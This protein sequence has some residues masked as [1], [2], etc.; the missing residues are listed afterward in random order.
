[1]QNA[2]EVWRVKAVSARALCID[3][4]IRAAVG[5]SIKGD[6]PAIEVPGMS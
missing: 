6:T 1:M 4:I 2:A 3:G 5:R